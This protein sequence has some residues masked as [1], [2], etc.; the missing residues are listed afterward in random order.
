M[1]NTNDA[2]RL[3]QAVQ[4]PGVLKDWMVPPKG[5]N[6]CPRT[7]AMSSGLAGEPSIRGERLSLVLRGLR[8][9][10]DKTPSGRRG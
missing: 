10:D 5:L 4:L 9:P 2:E 1:G 6:S 7:A 8:R 3:G